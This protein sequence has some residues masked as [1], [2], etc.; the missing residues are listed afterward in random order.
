MFEQL[1]VA[2]AA[3]GVLYSLV[4]LAMTVVWRAT[5]LVNFGHGDLVMGGAFVA[6]VLVVKLGV[7]YVPAVVLGLA[8]LFA[9]GVGIQRGLIQPIKAAPHLALAMMA[10][11]VGYSIRGVARVF[12][13]RDI[14]PFPSVF[15]R[16]HFEFGGVIVTGDDLTVVSVVLVLMVVF[17][18]IFHLSPLGRLIQAVFQSQRGAALIGLNVNAFHNTMWGIGALMAALGGALLAPVTLLYPDMAAWV[19]IRGFAAMTLGG[20]GSLHGAV[21]G[22]ILLGILENLVGGYVSTSLIEITAYLVIIGVLLIRP[23]GLFGSRIIVRV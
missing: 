2:G 9:V 8:F 5:S 1:V 7:P 3:H 22:G 19:L 10:I 11:A 12:W 21:I 13:A 20:F 6:Y 4:A 15:P 23:V 14:L 16:Q 17:F 18:A